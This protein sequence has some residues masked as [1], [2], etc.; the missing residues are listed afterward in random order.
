MFLFSSKTIPG[1]ER[2]VI[3]IINAFSK[4]ALMW[5]M[6]ARASITYQATPTGLTLSGCMTL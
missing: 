4:M 6:I 1:N 3:G 5:W 2:G